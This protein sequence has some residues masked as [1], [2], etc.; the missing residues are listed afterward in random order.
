MGRKLQQ[1]SIE[2]IGGLLRA[3]RSISGKT[4]QEVESATG[5]KISA[6]RDMEINKKSWGAL[7]RLV[8]LARLYQI[9]ITKIIELADSGPDEGKESSL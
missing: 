8:T 7:K 4:L 1:I 9:P 6:I 3:A 5:I 2:T